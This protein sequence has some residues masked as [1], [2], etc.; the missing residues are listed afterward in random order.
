MHNLIFVKKIYIPPNVLLLSLRIYLCTVLY[1][2]EGK[3]Y[4]LLTMI[5]SRKSAWRKCRD[6]IIKLS[7]YLFCIVQHVTI[8]YFTTE[9]SNKTQSRYFLKDNNV[10]GNGIRGEGILLSS[11]YHPE[12]SIFSPKRMWIKKNF[13]SN[14]SFRNTWCLKIAEHRIE[15]MLWLQDT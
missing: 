4:S 13:K 10:L 12:L 1:E 7:L 11:L 2:H 8:T 3:A 6:E 15:S 5:T 9:K 14:N